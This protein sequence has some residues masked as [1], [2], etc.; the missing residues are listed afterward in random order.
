V[1]ATVLLSSYDLIGL[2]LERQ[3]IVWILDGN[4]LFR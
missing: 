1:N 3:G 2:N 4:F